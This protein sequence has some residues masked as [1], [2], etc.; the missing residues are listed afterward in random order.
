MD[1]VVSVVKSREDLEKLINYLKGDGFPALRK[2]VSRMKFY[3]VDEKTT[4]VEMARRI[5]EDPGLSTRLL[6]VANSPVFN[7]GLYRVRTVTRAIVMLG[8][9]NV[10][11][12]IRTIAF[13]EDVANV[14]EMARVIDKI[15]MALKKAELARHLAETTMDFLPEEV[16]LGALMYD[17]GDIIYAAFVDPSV[18][19]QIS[20]IAQEKRVPKQVVQRNIL[21]YAPADITA[22]LNREWKVSE[23]IDDVFS[24]GKKSRKS[25]MVLCAG[26][27]VE[28]IESSDP[29]A[30]A[31]LQS[32]LKSMSSELKI[33]L[34][35]V[36]ECIKKA[37]E[38]FQR[39][40]KIYESDLRKLKRYVR[41]DKIEEEERE[42]PVDSEVSYEIPSVKP[43]SLYRIFEI[44]NDIISMMFKGF[45]DPHLLFSLVMEAIY[46]GL[47]MDVAMFGLLSTD[48]KCFQIRHN[49]VKPG[50]NNVKIP[51]SISFKNPRMNL[52]ID[53]LNLDTSLWISENSPPELLAKANSVP[54]SGIVHIPCFLM[55][56]R[57]KN[58]TIG[59]IYADCRSRSELID[60]NSFMIFTML[61]QLATIGLSFLVT[62]S[63]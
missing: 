44:L 5:L 30:S 11:L 23:V 49:L 7:P 36:V 63:Q 54:A 31:K 13:L 50:I 17:I 41:K 16:F 26:R 21:G 39:L 32:F 34:K 53:L 47:D 58:K 62:E 52:F 60:E 37:R 43:D 19:E 18:D 15:V 45:S 61:G 9:R 56:V 10:M 22:I 48:R 33:P 57:P 1:D 6:K 59:F 27:V 24:P 2:T 55:P 4:I 20:R 14:K 28:L 12:I 46:S 29:E 40:E 38:D 42:A 25:K 3:S 51:E 35:S 8:I